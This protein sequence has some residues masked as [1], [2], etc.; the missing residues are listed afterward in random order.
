MF[1]YY[2]SP[3]DPTPLLLILVFVALVGILRFLSRPHTVMR[4]ER[5]QVALVRGS[6]PSGL[7]SDLMDVA[8]H[9]PEAVGQIAL[10]GGGH[11]LDLKTPG[12][13]EAVAQRVRNV[14]FLYR[15]RI[16]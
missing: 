1:G 5:G 13:D 11:K 7:L 3:M 12:L 9:A 2:T 6:P 4:L 10:T 16:R 8:S 15:D 14:V